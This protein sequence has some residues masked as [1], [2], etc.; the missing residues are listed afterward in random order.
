MLYRNYESLGD[1]RRAARSL[2]RYLELRPN[3]SNAAEYRQWIE[4]LEGN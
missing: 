1:S 2:R 4:E 3:D